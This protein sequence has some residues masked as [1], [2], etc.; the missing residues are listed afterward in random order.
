MRMRTNRLVVSLTILV[1]A[2]MAAGFGSRHEPSVVRIHS[3]EAMSTVWTSGC[4]YQTDRLGGDWQGLPLREGDLLTT[5]SVFFRYFTSDGP[6]LDVVTGS[7]CTRLAG[8][9][10]GVSLQADSSR[11]W[12]ASASKEDLVRLR[13]VS[14]AGSSAV[15]SLDAAAL[16]ALDRLAAVNADVGFSVDSQAE[17]RQVLQRFRPPLLILYE[18]AADLRGERAGLSRLET[19]IL[20]AKAAGSLDALPSLPRLRRLT[21]TNWDVAVA[22]PLPA[23]M[24]GLESLVIFGDHAASSARA[25]G[26]APAGL[27]ELTIIPFNDEPVDLGCLANLPALRSLDLGF[28]TSAADLA[29]LVTL[30]K[31]ERIGLP[32]NT[33]QQQFAAIVGRHP[34]LRAVEMVNAD[35]VTDLAPLRGLKRLERLVL[36]SR[37]RDLAPLNELRSLRYV[38]LACDSTRASR[39]RLLELRKAL[40]D[41][42]V[43]PVKPL[44]LGSGWILLLVPAA[45]VCWLPGR[46]TRRPR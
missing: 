9:I 35:S 16:S 27:E 24:K 31:L 40:P 11:R 34:G 4:G 29:G 45:A 23:G 17:L 38:A 6:V 18:F 39:E 14:V 46:R 22:G 20:E 30:K 12:W 8:K 3:G 1:V 21:L 36:G 26:A 15:D 13:M 43:V 41:A 7:W 19:L 32:A 37:S 44:C 5:D 10:V 28:A 33:T 2:L 25:L 42:L